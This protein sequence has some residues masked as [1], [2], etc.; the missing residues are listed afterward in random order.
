ML[1]PKTPNPSAFHLPLT[2]QL[3]IKVKSLRTAGCRFIVF[4]ILQVSEQTQVTSALSLPH[5][6]INMLEVAQ[7]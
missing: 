1:S 2:N 4:T 5:L 7:V 6:S 3:S